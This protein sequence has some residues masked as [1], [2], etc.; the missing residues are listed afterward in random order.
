MVPYS[1]KATYG[2]LLGQR[3]HRPSSK[4][5][6]LFVLGIYYPLAYWK[7][8]KESATYRSFDEGR[9]KQVVMLIRTLFLKRFE[10]SARAFEGSCWRLLQ[11]LLAWVTVHAKS[12]HDQRRLERWKIKHGDLIGYVQAH[13]LE[14]WPDEAERRRGR[15]VPERG[16]AQRDRPAGPGAS[17]MWTPSWTTPSTTW[18]SW[19]TF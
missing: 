5:N 12:E 16:C 17:S 11:K 9:Q 1:I 10:S 6:P 8:D 14:L 2:A 18:I 3:A 19:P 7:G 13:Q 4:D 15:G